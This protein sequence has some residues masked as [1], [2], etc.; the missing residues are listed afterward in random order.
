MK[1]LSRKEFIRIFY[2]LSACAI[3]FLLCKCSISISCRHEEAVENKPTIVPDVGNLHLTLN[4]SQVSNLLVELK[5]LDKQEL[6]FSE[7]ARHWIMNDIG[8]IDLNFPRAGKYKFRVLGRCRETNH[9]KT[10]HMDNLLVRF[11]SARWSPFPKTL[12][13]WN[14]YYKIEAP[15]SQHLL[16]KEN[17]KFRLIING[18]HDVAVLGPNGWYHMELEDGIWIGNVQTGPRSTRCRLLARFE[19]GS[20][21]FTEL[22]MFKV[23]KKCDIID[24]NNPHL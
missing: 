19:I 17:I 21:K 20:E 5:Y 18:A 23:R 9:M 7:H 16:E 6:N 12:E 1:G 3:L 15:L 2:S 8:H 22:L 10:L 4:T 13:E 14:S 11:P 24:Q